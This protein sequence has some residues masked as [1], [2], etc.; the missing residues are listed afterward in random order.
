G[1]GWNCGSCYN[2]KRSEGPRGPLSRTMLSDR[3]Y[4]LLTGYVD[5]VLSAR[6][7][8]TVEAF[9]QRSEEARSLLERLRRDAERVRSL[10][11]RQLGPDLAERV[12]QAIRERSFPPVQPIQV[13]RVAGPG[14]NRWALAAAVL[15]AVGGG[16]ILYWAS[17]PEVE[18]RQAVEVQRDRM[19]PTV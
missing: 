17:S 14:W 16:S 18:K 10:P 19:R 13:P 4:R 1:P 5:G 11:R 9:L 7:R 8:R 3:W 15:L 2:R 12:L 6:E